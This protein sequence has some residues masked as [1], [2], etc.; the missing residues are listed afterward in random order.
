MS[1]SIFDS[2]EL[3]ICYTFSEVFAFPPSH[4]NS[5]SKLLVVALE[6]CTI[7]GSTS[8]FPQTPPDIIFGKYESL[9]SSAPWDRHPATVKLKQIY[10][11]LRVRTFLG[12]S[13]R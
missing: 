6:Q 7:A 11:Y 4:E 8:L 13:S 10:A 9:V 5:N 2:T 3:L 1:A 12:L